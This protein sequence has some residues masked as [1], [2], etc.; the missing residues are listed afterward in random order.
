MNDIDQMAEWVDDQLGGLEVRRNMAVGLTGDQPTTTMVQIE[1]PPPFDSP[2]EAEQHGRELAQQLEEDGAIDADR[3]DQLMEDF[4]P[5]VNNPDVMAG[6]YMELDP[7]VTEMLPSLLH[8]SGADNAEQYLEQFSTGLGTALSTTDNTSSTSDYYSELSDVREHFRQPVDSPGMA[9]D[10]LA[11]LQH[12][13]FPARFVADVARNGVLDQLEGDEWDQIDYR[14][15]MTQKLGLSG[16]TLALAFGALGNNPSAARIALD[17]KADISLEEYTNRVY[18]MEGSRG[19]GD[20]IVAGYGQALAAGSGA[21]EDPPDKGH[22]A[23]NFAFEVIQVLGQH[24]D[25]PWGMRDPMG[26]IGAAYAEEL[27]IGSYSHEHANRESS[28]DIPEDFELPPGTDPAFLLNPEDVY[29]FL[30]GFAHDDTHSQDFDRAVENLY[31]TLPNQAI[32]ADLETTQN[33]E[34]DPQNLE[35]VMRMF[36]TLGGLQHQA[37]VEVRGSQFDEEEARRKRF[38]QVRN[39]LLG[40]AAGTTRVTGAMWKAMQLV[41]PNAIDDA[42]G[43]NPDPREALADKD[44]R[45]GVLERYTLAQTMADAGYPTSEEAPADLFDRDPEKILDDPEYAA[46]VMEDLNEWTENNSEGDPEDHTFPL[47]DKYNSAWDAIG[48]GRGDVSDQIA[49]RVDWQE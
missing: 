40:E 33:G 16:D 30:H 7:Q 32:E 18:G 22:H 36:G 26:Q 3:F 35:A 31:E 48:N 44:L 14:G 29:R 34:R 9:W 6:F 27:L 28:M 47:Q 15:S 13:D 17:E 8:Q 38:A 12:G 41:A 46:Q 25:T 4:G 43:S 19:T 45:V 1:E 24:E 49:D 37:Q 23:S 10:R 21:L 2:E 11:M 5:Y 39:F 42:L 20:D